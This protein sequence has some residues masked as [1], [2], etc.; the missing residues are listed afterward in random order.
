[1]IPAG[2]PPPVEV[3]AERLV[4]E[5]GELIATGDVVVDYAGQTLRADE[6]VFDLDAQVLVLRGGSLQRGEVV[7]SFQGATVTVSEERALLTG[8]VVDGLG[9]HLTG[10]QLAVLPDGTLVVRD[11][12]ATACEATCEHPVPWALKA[13][14][15]TVEPGDQLHV[16]GAWI[17][18]L[19]VPVIPVPA[20]STSLDLHEPHLEAPVVGWV[21]GHPALRLPVR[22]GHPSGLTLRASAGYW[23]GPG[24]DIAGSWGD[25]S[26][27]SS[28]LLWEEGALRGQ[29]SVR[30]VSV[31]TGLSLGVHGQLVSDPRWLPERGRTL[32]E[33]TAPWSDVRA[34]ASF[35]PAQLW[36][37]G[38]QTAAPDVAWTPAAVLTTST[39]SLGPLWGVGTGR[40]DL[41]DGQLRSEARGE[42][43]GVHRGTLLE[44]QA[45]ITARA[46]A[47]DETP[48]G[49][50]GAAVGE[51]RVPLW[52]D[53]A[54]GRQEWVAGVRA[55]AG[56]HWGPN[57]AS[58]WETWDQGVVVGP[59]VEALTWGA[60]GTHGWA[61]VWVPWDGQTWGVEGQGAVVHGPL[62]LRGQASWRG[63][64]GLVSGRVG[65]TGETG[66]AWGE[67][68][69]GEGDE[70]A[71][72]ARAGGWVG[73]DGPHS[74]WDLT[75]DAL[76]D[77]E[78]LGEV[79]TGLAWAAGCDCLALG[80]GLGW[81]RDQQ[82]PRVSLW[83]D[84]T[85]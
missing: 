42:L 77:A 84:A 20:W 11:A 1:V 6:A 61:R 39:R 52:R 62:S 53:G 27:A 64:E 15:A 43:W 2:V 79:R 14:T 67:A 58:P 19:G 29:A 59:Q 46:L 5:D 21:D 82:G 37:T 71:L 69:L 38:V 34:Q 81:A 7:M 28:E 76:G 32:A 44:A 75:V 63:G 68:A 49:L 13:R 31:S 80:T 4:V 22:W 30:H 83:L 25:D 26:Q 8:V 40:F 47:Y 74:S 65:W 3:Q 70:S 33:R 17:R 50:D 45:G 54:W 73:L 10:E 18:V 85:P 51:V 60:G 56:H 41:V 78:G 16:K 48:G 23:R 55:Q 24:T 57:A 35:G 12:L 66:G 72:L 36:L 9:W